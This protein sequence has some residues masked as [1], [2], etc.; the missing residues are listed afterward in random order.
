M[1][2][3]SRIC[4]A[5]GVAMIGAGCAITQDAVV[6][7]RTEWRGRPADEFFARMGPPMSRTVKADGSTVYL[8]SSASQRVPARRTARATP[9]PGANECRVQ[10][11]A[12]RRDVVVTIR[13]MLDSMELFSSTVCGELFGRPA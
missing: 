3:F 11:T 8:W 5:A 6:G 4:V 2:A 10:I 1:R 12:D 13:P 9:A 7:V